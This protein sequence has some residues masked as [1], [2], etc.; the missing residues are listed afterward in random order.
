MRTVLLSYLIHN[1]GAT[2][3]FLGF[4]ENAQVSL[5][6]TYLREKPK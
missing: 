5:L 6:I 4:I 1:C 3:Y 2:E